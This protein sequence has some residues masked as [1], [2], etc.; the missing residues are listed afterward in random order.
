MKK[1]FIRADGGYGIG[2]GHIMRMVTLAKQLQEYYEVIFICR[3]GKKFEAGINEAKK[4]YRVLQIRGINIT[5]EV[6]E[7]QQSENAQCIITDSYE[8]DENYFDALKPYFRVTCYV[9]DVNICRMNVDLIINQNITAYKY[10]YNTY[11]N[12]NTKFLLGSKYLILRDEFIKEYSKDIKQTVKTMMITV[13]GMD[14]K[15]LTLK[16]VRALKDIRLKKYIIIGQ[17]FREEL[18]SELKKYESDEVV[19]CFNA[20]MSSIM[21]KSD[22]AI[23]S[24]GSTL[25]ELCAMK[26][27]TIGIV[28]ASNQ[29]EIAK[30]MNERGI[31]IDIGDVDLI[32]FDN[33]HKTIKKLCD[34]VNIRNDMICRA[35]REVNKYGKYNI[36]EFINEMI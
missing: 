1:I 9:D 35:N 24:C 29:K 31:I 18:I 11:P 4:E 12:K 17:S 3:I 26:V 10:T 27:P 5:E 28:V 6:I 13:G 21:E 20:K 36:V 23:S 30:L 33:I 34:E 32:N 2:M 25:Y 22:L 19:L 8:V 7:L 15:F 14:D 16:L